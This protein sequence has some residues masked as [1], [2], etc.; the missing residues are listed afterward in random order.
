MRRRILPLVLLALLLPALVPAAVQAATPPPTKLVRVS[1]GPMTSLTSLLT[2]GFDVVAVRGQAAADL[3]ASPDDEARLRGLGAVLEVLD[4]DVEGHYAAR[5]Q[6]GL[7]ARPRSEPARVRSAVRPDGVFRIEALPAFGSGSMGGYWTLAEVKMKLDSLVAADTRDLVADKL[8]TL[9]WTLQSRPIW[10]LKIGKRVSGPDTRPVVFFNAL[11]HA[12]EPEGMQAVFWYVDDLLAKYDTDP[13]AKYL[14]DQRVIYICPVVNPDGYELNRSRYPGGGGMHRKNVRDV[15][16]DGLV[17]YQTDGVD[18]NRNYGFMWGYDDV[19]SSPTPTNVAYRG[20]SG[21]SEPETQVQRDI[22]TALQ[23]VTCVTFHTYSNLFIHPWSYVNQATRDSM[24]YYE[25]DDEAT[26][27]SGYLS[28]LPARTLYPVNGDLDDWCYG[29]TLSKP[30]VITWTPELGTANDGFWP[31]PVRIV[32]LAQENLRKCYLVTAIA[33]PWVR[34]ERS[35]VLEGTLDAGNLAH[36]AVRARNRGLAATPA[37]LLATLSPLDAGV[38]VFPGGTT[39]HYPTLAPLTSADASAGETFIIA[40]ED[41]VTP[42]RLVRFEVAFTADGGFFSRDTV[43]LLV[44]RPTV[45][46]VEPFDATTLWT[47]SGGWS[48][49]SND[50]GHPSRYMTDSPLG[51]YGNSSNLRL[52]YKGRLDLSAG[53]HA[54]ALF[55]ARWFFEPAFDG[56]VFEASLDSAYWVAVPGRA[57]VPGYYLPQPIGAPLYQG[58]RMLWQTERLDLSSFA[59]PGGNLVRLRLRTVSDVGTNYDGFSFDSL[60]VLLYDPAQQPAP[61]A[62]GPAAGDALELAVPAP[63]PARSQAR[64]AFSL[65]RAGA[66]RLEVF[67]LAGRRVRTLAQG[68]YAAGRYALAWDLRDDAGRAVAPGVYLARLQGGSGERTRRLVVLR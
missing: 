6:A 39:A 53:V 65:P 66:V 20:S 64:L 24:A 1:L 55:D 19:G 32:P 28:G 22:V 49:V 42:G 30:R 11:T 44:G 52:I 27:G 58:S 62:V 37:N 47:W 31:P 18:L 59:G 9:G 61:A 57:T 10:G 2:A 8:D 4:D 12:R 45:V 25:W 38:E 43:E 3:F 15:D 21:F 7:A 17:D 16:G 48:L 35:S 60:R 14:L 34:V 51:A 50:P 41:S 63:N 54:Y 29:D 13:F 67:D 56:T 36:L 33:G 46:M 68:H 26:L 40:A 5:A 23:P